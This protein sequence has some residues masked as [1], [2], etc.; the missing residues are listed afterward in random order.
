MA[1]RKKEEPAARGE[2]VNQDRRDEPGG[3]DE[4]TEEVASYK[5]RIVPTTGGPSIQ[6][7]GE[8]RAAGGLA[9]GPVAARA[10]WPVARPA[11]LWAVRRVD[12]LLHYGIVLRAGVFLRKKTGLT[13]EYLAGSRNCLAFVRGRVS[14]RPHPY[15]KRKGS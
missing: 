13:E 5:M 9:A 11:T 4:Y 2:P 6:E 8:A 1:R 7:R 3:E 10:R 12:Q 14:L 15:M